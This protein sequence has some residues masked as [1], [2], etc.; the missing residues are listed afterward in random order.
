M[1]KTTQDTINNVVWKACDTDNE[2]N[3]RKDRR[4]QQR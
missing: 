4:R 3:A 1:Q 2:Q